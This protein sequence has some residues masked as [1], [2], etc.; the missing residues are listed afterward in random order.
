[1]STALRLRQRKSSRKIHVRI[2]IVPTTGAKFMWLA[3]KAEIVP[4][5]ELKDAQ[6]C[7]QDGLLRGGHAFAL[8]ARALPGCLHVPPTLVSAC[9][10]HG[11]GSSCDHTACLV[12]GNGRGLAYGSGSAGVEGKL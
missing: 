4:V 2:T 11:R 1:M 12:V 8:N 3:I 9:I 10:S 5:L 6:H 7:R